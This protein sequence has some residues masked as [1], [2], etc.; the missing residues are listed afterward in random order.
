MYRLLV[1][2]CRWSEECRR[3]AV[4]AVFGRVTVFVS[5]R[6]CQVADCC[7]F[8]S[9]FAWGSKRTFCD[10]PVRHRVIIP[11]LIWTHIWAMR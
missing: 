8:C 3:E 10:F 6:L 11:I 4:G 5:S 1:E 7:V 2:T 9:H